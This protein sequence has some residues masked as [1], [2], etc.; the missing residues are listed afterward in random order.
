MDLL[1]IVNNLKL[2]LNISSSLTTGEL[3]LKFIMNLLY[4]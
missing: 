2:I 4:D 1:G 3:S